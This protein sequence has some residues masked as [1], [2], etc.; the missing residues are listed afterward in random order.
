[1][2]MD[3]PMES[4]QLENILSHVSVLRLA[5][6][7]PRWSSRA[8]HGL[9]ELRLMGR[10]TID[11]SDLVGI[12][13]SSPGL[14]IL[15]LGLPINYSLPIDTEVAPV[16]L[17]DLEVLLVWEISCE[18]IPHLLR[19][20]APGTKPLQ[21]GFRAQQEAYMHREALQLN[22]GSMLSFFLRSHLN[23][24]YGRYMS[25]VSAI[26]LLELSPGIQELAISRVKFDAFPPLGGAAVGS[27]LRCRLRYLQISHSSVDIEAVLAFISYPTVTIEVVVF[28]DCQLFHHGA[29]IP[30]DQ[31]ALQVEELDAN[32][33][34]VRFIVRSYKEPYLVHVEMWGRDPS[35]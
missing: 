28:H 10:E 9:A 21:F 16:V 20:L 29:Q 6:P 5:G 11:E 7:Y 13:Q 19:R 27:T 33:P 8:Y 15:Q 24:V 12:L 32:Y 18:S 25:I 31:V 14:R 26:E 2:S 17:S 3:L 35:L 1:M 4:E 23:S 30:A 34:N 22:E